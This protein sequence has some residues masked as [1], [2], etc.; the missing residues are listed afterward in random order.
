SPPAT[1]ARASD[2]PATAIAQDDAA[3]ATESSGVPAWIW[4]ALAV[5]VV[6]GA[7]VGLRAAR[8]RP[9]GEEPGAQ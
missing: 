8:R 1:D 7:V 4:V 3:S 6:L 9:G 2:A 5:L